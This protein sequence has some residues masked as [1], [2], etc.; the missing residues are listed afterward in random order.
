VRAVRLTDLL[1]QLEFPQTIDYLSID[2]EGHEVDVLN[3]LDLSR[4]NF[5]P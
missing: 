4:F 3:G 2:V 1:E 5:K